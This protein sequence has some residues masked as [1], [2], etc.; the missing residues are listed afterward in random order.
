M[1]GFFCCQFLWFL[2]V[3]VLLVWFGFGFGGR[4]L[5]SLVICV[6]AAVEDRSSR[7]NIVLLP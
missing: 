7:R 2:V 3:L 1:V 5:V 4:E 6:P